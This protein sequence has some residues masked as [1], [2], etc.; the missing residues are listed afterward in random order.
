MSHKDVFKDA[1]YL[2]EIICGNI[3]LR[4][5]EDCREIV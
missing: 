3:L 4:S 5:M 2:N 1:L